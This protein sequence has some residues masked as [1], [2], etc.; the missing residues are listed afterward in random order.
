MEHHGAFEPLH[1]P[2]GVRLTAGQF[3]ELCQLNR[4]W[5]FER[6]AEGAIVIM[7]PT[8]GATGARNAEIAAQLRQWAKADGT[9]VS[10]D[11]ST[12]FELPS[13]ATRSPDAAWV[14]R[15]R[16]AALSERDKDDFVPLCPDFVIELRSR[17]DR[18]TDLIAKM[19]EY[20]ANGAALGWL[21]D[22]IERRVHVFR[23][24]QPPE[25]LDEPSD[26][27][28]EPA[29]PGFHLDLRDIWSPGF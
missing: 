29:L 1:L 21:I 7:P 23:P 15:A 2:E 24:G 3:R 27:S 28:A 6:T 20:A 22:P 16:L 25:R 14:R 10:F 26:L 9:G 17:S 8:G 18:V 19:A 13:G 5:R 4:D 12:G 11:S